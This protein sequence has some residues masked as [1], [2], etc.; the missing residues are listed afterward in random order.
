[1]SQNANVLNYDGT[2]TGTANYETSVVL[3]SWSSLIFLANPA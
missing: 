2:I 1:M 3:K